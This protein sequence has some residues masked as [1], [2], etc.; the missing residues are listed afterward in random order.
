[1]SIGYL[2]GCRLE[3]RRFPRSKN[4]KVYKYCKCIAFER[5]INRRKTN[6]DKKR[7]K[8][9]FSSVRNA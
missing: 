7:E 1:M 4:T 5:V 9:T 3:T 2:R 6:G 8:R